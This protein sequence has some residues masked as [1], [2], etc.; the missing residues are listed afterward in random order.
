MPVGGRGIVALQAVIISKRKP[1]HAWVQVM[2]VPRRIADL[3]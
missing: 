2:Y 1:V 3:V